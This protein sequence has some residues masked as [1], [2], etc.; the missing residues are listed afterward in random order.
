MPKCQ[1]HY[2]ATMTATDPSWSTTTTTSTCEIT[3]IIAAPYP[4]GIK[5][6]VDRAAP[7]ERTN[8]STLAC[9][10]AHTSVP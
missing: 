2:L 7:C 10:Q 6:G 3:W 8:M 9:A 4:F 1:A 5:R